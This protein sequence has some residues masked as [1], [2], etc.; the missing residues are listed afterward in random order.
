MKSI[1]SLT[2]LMVIISALSQESVKHIVQAKDQ[3][4]TIYLNGAEMER[5]SG[6]NLKKGNNLLVFKGIS[7]NLDSKSIRVSSD[8]EI[9]VLSISTKTDY[10]TKKN[11][12]PVIKSIKDSISLL[13][14]QKKD[15]TDEINAYTSEK[16]MIM[17][18]KSIGGTN[19]GV[20]IAEL[21]QGAD[22]FRQR[23][24]E[25]NKKIS[26][27]EKSNNEL[28][29]LLVKYNNELNEVNARS[30]YSESEIY[31]LLSSEQD[32]NTQIKLQYLVTNAGWVPGYDIK[33]SDLNN[34]IEL[35]YKAQVYNN[36]GI[37]WEN[38]K[39]KLSIADPTLSISIPELK[40]W[41]LDY[42]NANQSYKL[43]KNIGYAQN[44]AVN[45]KELTLNDEMKQE[46]TENYDEFD[47]PDL[48]T[49]FEIKQQ[50]SIPSDDKPYVVEI[51]KYSL[52][53]SFKHFA[54]TKLDK[55]VFLLGKITGWENLNLVDGYANVYLKGTFLGQSFI[56]TRN[57]K[58]TL[59]LSLGRDEKVLVTRTKLKEF[60]SKQLIGNKLKETL[61]FELVAKNNRNTAVDLEILD[62]IPI[63]SNSDIEVK[64]IE[65]SQGEYNPVTGEVKWKYHL[66][67]GES[68]KMILT[69]SIKYSKNQTIEIQQMKQ[70]SV[71]KF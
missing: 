65:I 63:S 31:I 17:T 21:K 13:E 27:L 22:F 14:L 49:E 61:S 44:I 11:E 69:F 47:I 33:A 66:N 62:Q 56:K 53:A 26:K 38:I 29:N 68:R 64:E 45:E 40:P 1:L 15:N 6:F 32:A 70:R 20:P 37:A 3:S 50:Y 52:P 19:N 48:N 59:D 71:R 25:I 8:V 54:V 9:S 39:I 30:T 57:V 23:I 2:F 28:D 60:S 24:I 12:I 42:Y 41:Y 16:E 35:V 5:S 46:V 55:G 18:N 51:E 4:A 43:D 7:P 58:D 67:P 10:L 34:P 36:T